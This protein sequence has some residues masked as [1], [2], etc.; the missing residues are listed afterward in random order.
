MEDVLD[1]NSQEMEKYL[2]YVSHK[3]FISKC[4]RHGIV[5]EGFKI[6]W[7]IQIDCSDEILNKCEKIKQDASVE[8]HG[9]HI[10]SL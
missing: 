4:V 10:G 5:P 6:N 7:N 8:T 1:C 3:D 2:R 9:T